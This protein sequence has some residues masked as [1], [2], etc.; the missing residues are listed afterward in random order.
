MFYRTAESVSP[1]HPDKLCDQI[2]DAILD[3]Y[4]A[5]D[6]DA[7]VAAEACGGH[8]VVFVTGEITSTVDVDIP[9]V[10]KRIAGDVEV[11]TKIV[12][13]SPEIAQGVDTGGAGDQGIMIGYACDETPEMLPLE[14]ILAR[15]LNQYIYEKYPYDGKTQVT[16]AP[17]GTIDSIVASFQNV[18]K[19]ELEKLVR[20]FVEKEGLEGK[21]ELHI[22]PAG[23]WQQGGF[24][25]DTGL[26]G[27]K[28]IVDN[29]GPRVA[30]GGGCYSGKD[31]SKVDRSAAYMAR[32]I[33]V[34]YLRKR[35][36]HEVLVRLAYAIGYAEPLEKTV[37]VDGE[38]EE[39]EGY[40]LTPNGIIK[41]L[42][43][44]RPIYEG[45]ACYGHYG[46]G[47]DWDK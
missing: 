23:D 7:R 24:D 33:A 15:R 29:Y 43:L 41:F 8:G 16:I 27:R 44:K 3:A 2:S 18:P 45:T 10:V 11:H 42:D 12:K 39:I 47:F 30:I 37:I 36:A 14:V 26:T 22:N 32:R 5:A 13:Q 40:D 31:P 20:E 9:S 4:L 17:D 19:G 6:P 34:D 1:K 38:A 35:K 21:L 28:L 25:A 46:E